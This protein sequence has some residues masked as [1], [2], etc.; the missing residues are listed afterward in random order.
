MSSIALQLVLNVYADSRFGE[1]LTALTL[2][3]ILVSSISAF[4][5]GYCESEEFGM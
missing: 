5:T 3:N 2:D 1:G 4:C